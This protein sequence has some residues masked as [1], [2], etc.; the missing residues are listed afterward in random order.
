VFQFKNVDCAVDVK[1]PFFCLIFDLLEHWTT[2][3]R[4]LHR[5]AIFTQPLYETSGVTFRVLNAMV[6]R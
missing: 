1:I 4:I 2:Q 6:E 5:F 3:S